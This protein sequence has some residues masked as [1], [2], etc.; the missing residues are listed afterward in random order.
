MRLSYG[1]GGWI[2]VD[3]VD[4][5]GPLYLRMTEREGRLRISEFYL[6]AS[7]G[8]DGID[9]RDLRELPLSW[10]E[11]FINADP[12]PV[13]SR[14]G[15]ASPDLST[16]ASYYTT[17]FG[18]SARQVAEGNWVVTS[19]VSQM[20]PAG[21]T[22]AVLRRHELLTDEDA[23]KAL[24][25]DATLPRAMHVER[26]SPS[27]GWQGVRTSERE[28]RLKS[29]PTAG[30]T[31]D[32]LREVA[33]AYM[34]AMAREERPNVA[35]AEQTGYPI[36]TVQRWVYTARQRGIMPRGKKGSAG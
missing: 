28:F 26:Q 2:A 30:L 6:D 20:L 25:A 13:K 11:A 17:S 22:R 27:K 33:R 10:I 19:F 5:P 23:E 14:M 12:D 31:D 15:S 32:F 8:P 35:I 18:S 34:G 16:L 1:N 4:L 9:A 3:G 29:G 36:K 24:E 21:A 7:R